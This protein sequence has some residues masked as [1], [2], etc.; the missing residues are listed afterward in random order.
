MRDYL[1]SVIPEAKGSLTT[2][3]L[4][5]AVRDDSRVPTNRMAVVLAESDLIKFAARPVSAERARELGGEARTIA[6][7]V[8]ERIAAPSAPQQAEAA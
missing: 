7:E 2:G 6:H 5:G 4:L 8:H 1:A 3:E